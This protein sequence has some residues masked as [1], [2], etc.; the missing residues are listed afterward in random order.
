MSVYNSYKLF[1]FRLDEAEE[2]HECECELEK[3]V[4]RLATALDGVGEHLEALENQ[5]QFLTE[6]IS[7]R[8]Q[9]FQQELLMFRTR[10]Q[11]SASIQ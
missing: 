2:V 4:E 7:S 6:S 9:S 1:V 11:V 10:H 5:F 3:K 8:E